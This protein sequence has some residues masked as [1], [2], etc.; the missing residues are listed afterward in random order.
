LS[1]HLIEKPLMR[2]ERFKR[3]WVAAVLLLLISLAL[4]WNATLV[5]EQLGLRASL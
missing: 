1:H 3:D 2:S 5:I 4:V